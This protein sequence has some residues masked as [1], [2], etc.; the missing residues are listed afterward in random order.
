MGVSGTLS[1]DDGSKEATDARNYAGG[2]CTCIL[3]VVVGVLS[4]TMESGKLNKW[5]LCDDRD[6]P[7]TEFFLAVDFKGGNNVKIAQW[8]ASRAAFVTHFLVEFLEF[9]SS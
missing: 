9:M 1:R 4:Q 5:L 7:H 3:S 8:T 2:S 6:I